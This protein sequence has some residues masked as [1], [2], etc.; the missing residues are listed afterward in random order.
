MIGKLALGL[1]SHQALVVGREFLERRQKSALAREVADYLGK[2]LLVVGGPYG[3]NPIRHLFQFAAHPAGDVCV[4]LDPF[5]CTGAPEYVQSDI[6]DLPFEDGEFG[7]AFSSHVLEHTPSA[8]DCALAWWELHR[9]ADAVFVCVPTRAD[10]IAHLPRDHYL[11]V[12][13]LPG[14][15][16]RVQERAG[17]QTYLIGLTPGD[18]IQVG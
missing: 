4:D 3:T 18:I 14:G 16:L 10:L 9:V 12:Q 7:A 13:E 6:R 17:G 15:S 2:P 5:A 11:W 1:L 8:Y